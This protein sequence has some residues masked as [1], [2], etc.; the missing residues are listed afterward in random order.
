MLLRPGRSERGR[1]SRRFYLGAAAP[2]AADLRPGDG[3]KRD[4][5][6]RA[7][8]AG[9]LHAVAV[10]ELNASEPKLGVAPGWS[11]PSQ[12]IGPPI[13][14]GDLVWATHWNENVSEGG[15]VLYGI[16][17]ATGHVQFEESLGA[18]EHFAT[19]SAGGGRLFV[20]NNDELTAFGI[21]I[22][23]APSATSTLLASSANPSYP[24]TEVGLTAS[25]SPVPDSGS[26]AF[27][28]GGVPIPGCGAVGVS[29][30]SGGA[31]TCAAPFAAAG[32]HTILATSFRRRVLRRVHILAAGANGRGRLRGSSSA[33]DPQREPVPRPLARGLG[34]RTG[35]PQRVPSQAARRHDV[36][37]HAQRRRK[38][39][40]ALH[41]VHA[42]PEGGSA[43]P[44]HA[45]PQTTW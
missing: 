28:D 44:I 16:D 37:V 38:R 14:A 11:N 43:L 34:P 18:F 17:P 42:W 31:A 10:S 36:L 23:P 29:L 6:T 32:N 3:L 2:G 15:G 1:L 20:A 41:A 35:E 45:A 39:E 27:T 12:A 8:S 22:P 4:A 40:P 19:P 24:G 21:A 7:A 33:V 30:A 25:V 9:G 13:F 26:V 5:L